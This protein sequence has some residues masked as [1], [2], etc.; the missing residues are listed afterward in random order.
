MTTQLFEAAQVET[1]VLLTGC[2]CARTVAFRIHDLSSHHAERFESVDCSGTEEELEEELFQRLTCPEQTRVS[3]LFVEEVGKLSRAQQRRLLEALDQP[4]GG[5][6]GWTR[7]IACSSEALIDRVISG[8]FDD[9]LFYRLN[10]IHLHLYEPDRASPP[11][12]ALHC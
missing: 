3:T 7:V 5:S 10:T 2:T 4:N 12:Q 11:P 8:T 9:R 1:C 6:Q